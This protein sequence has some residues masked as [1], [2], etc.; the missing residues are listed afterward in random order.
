M[1]LSVAFTNGLMKLPFDNVVPGVTTDDPELETLITRLRAARTA[2]HD[3]SPSLSTIDAVLVPLLLFLRQRE[4]FREGPI[5]AAPQELVAPD[6]VDMLL[7]D[8]TPESYV[9]IGIQLGVVRWSVLP[10]T[11]AA[12]PPSFPV[13]GILWGRNK[14]VMVPL[15]ARVGK[16]QPIILHFLLDTGSPF[17]FICADSMRALGYMESLPGESNFI[18]HGVSV[19]ATLSHS[20]FLHNDVLGTDWLTN[21]RAKISLDFASGPELPS[22]ILNGVP[23]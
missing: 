1:K 15:V 13:E 6:I 8:V 14:R 16:R 7:L 23:Y 12:E 3:G 11:A 18:L 20:H 10:P 17:T 4:T 5:D 21:A 19:S 9:D 2:L 22:V